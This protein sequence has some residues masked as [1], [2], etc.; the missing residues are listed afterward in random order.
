MDYKACKLNGL[1]SLSV[2]LV[3]GPVAY[4]LLARRCYSATEEWYN[5]NRFDFL[6]YR[7][8]I[9]FDWMV[10][11]RSVGLVSRHDTGARELFCAQNLCI[12]MS[13][14]SSCMRAAFGNSFDLAVR[15]SIRRGYCRLVSGGCSTVSRWRDG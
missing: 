4:W 8:T 7:R 1:K 14:C 13:S 9:D 5:I 3:D 15:L 11:P 10:P 6:P 12:Y 2:F